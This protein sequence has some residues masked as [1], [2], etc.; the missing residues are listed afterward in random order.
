MS[1]QRFPA[2]PAVR[3]LRVASLAAL[4]A[5]PFAAAVQADPAVSTVVAFS[6]STPAGNIVLG[7]DGALYGASAPTTSTSGGLIWRITP[8]A[9]SVTT[10][11]QLDKDTEGQGPQAGLI[12][13]SDGKLYGTT[14]FGTFGG[15]F[16]TTGT[17]FRVNED[18]TNFQVLHRF[19]DYTDLNDASQPKNTDGAYP[20]SELTEGSDGN[21]YGITSAGGTYGTGVIFRIGKDGSGFTV[22]HTLSELAGQKVARV[23][24][25]GSAAAD[26]GTTVSTGANQTVATL[27]FDAANT[28]M[29]VRIFSPTAGIKVR[30]KVQDAANS[31]HSAETEATTTLANGWS[32]LTF[33]FAN[34]VSG[35]PALD[36]SYTYN[37][38]SIY[39]DYGTTGATAGAKTY[40]FDD[41]T[42]VGG[43]GSF[44]PITFDATGVTYT[45]TGFS[46]ADDS[47]VVTDPSLLYRNAEGMLASAPLLEAP[48]GRLYGAAQSG[49]A[50]GR[51]T[52]FRLDIDGSDFQVIRTF[53]ATAID[54]TTSLVVNADGAGPSAGL[55][56]GGDGFL[57]G[58]TNFAGTK[59]HGTI[60][61]LD[62]TTLA[63]DVMHE[64][65]NTG[66]SRPLGELAL[67][68]DGRL[69]GTTSGGGTNASGTATTSGTLFSIAR[70]GTG[71][72]SL[73]SLDGSNGAVPTSQLVPLSSTL[74][75]GVASTGGN[76]GAGTLYR[77]DSTGGTIT[78]N[79]KCGR[80]KNSN[81]YGGGGATAPAVLLLLGGLG[82]ARRRRR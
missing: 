26:A 54:S 34:P 63:Y 27:P 17:I 15:S 50:E 47:T 46:G 41:V 56:D 20:T 79:T 82:L 72:T 66:G 65:D 14:K 11:H 81:S 7:S 73:I 75:A 5:L 69:Y 37:R 57:Y 1:S 77:Y 32:T 49:G 31:A 39:F 35:T 8:D 61:S 21:L 40:Y 36:F 30:L 38:I 55:I 48:D 25:S 2:V 22:L 70:D 74:I 24:K 53:P 43:A 9:S 76:C 33:D 12:K 28:R 59:G 58:V 78:G 45:L 71:F 62:L 3:S 4:V 44:S 10:I 6:G 80:K 29:T 42:F 18:G 23:V 67:F 16:K 68:A 64:F 13:G 60:F 19:A 51:G 52:L